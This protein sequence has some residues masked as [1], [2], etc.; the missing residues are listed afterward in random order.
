MRVIRSD[1]SEIILSLIR[2]GVNANLQLRAAAI[3][4]L[5]RPDGG[6]GT[7]WAATTKGEARNVAML[8]RWQSIATDHCTAEWLGAHAEKTSTWLAIRLSKS[9]QPV[10]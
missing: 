8:W 2:T 5:E 6:T 3:G 7:E 4:R 10:S 9:G 1:D